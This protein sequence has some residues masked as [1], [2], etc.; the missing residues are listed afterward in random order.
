V[1]TWRGL[2]TYYTV[3]VIDLASRRVP[4]LGSTPHPDVVFM[5]QGVRTLTIVEARAAPAPDVLICDRAR[6]WSGEVRRRLRDAGIRVVLTPARAPNANAY[7]ERFVRSIK[8]ECLDRLIPIGERHFRRTVAEYV[9]H[10]HGERNYQGLDNRRIRAR[11]PS[12]WP[13]ECDVGRG[14][15]C[16]TA[17]SE[18]HEGWSAEQWH[19]T[20]S[21]S[22]TLEHHGVGARFVCLYSRLGVTIRVGLANTRGS[23]LWKRMRRDHPARRCT[24][25]MNCFWTWRLFTRMCMPIPSC[26]CRRRVRRASRQT[27]YMRPVMK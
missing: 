10:Y 16:S 3:F 4:I 15:N 13:V 24:T 6:K 11:G 19:S 17:I 5:Q 22:H 18:R 25:S 2:I 21:R 23:E 12:R 20:T 9:E 1:W 26:R 8:E 14:L 7:A 27:V